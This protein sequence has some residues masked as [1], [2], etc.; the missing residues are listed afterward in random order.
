MKLM[1][2]GK[3]ERERYHGG[4]RL[5]SSVFDGADRSP[6]RL[7]LA[8]LHLAKFYILEVQG[9]EGCRANQLNFGLDAFI[10]PLA[11]ER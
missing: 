10:L 1:N 8:Q 3:R 7:A 4:V 2:N 11:M 9:C 5:A 6:I